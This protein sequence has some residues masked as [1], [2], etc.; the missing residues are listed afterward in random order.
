MTQSNMTKPPATESGSST[1]TGT[2]VATSERLTTDDGKISVAQ[3]VVS[4]I[5]G[6]ACRE[7]SG[8]HAMGTSSGRTFG[9][10]REAI[11]GSLGSPN[12]AQGVSVQVG[13]TQ[14]A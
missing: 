7:I 4:K 14:A 5:A 13:E 1:P 2:G 8:V 9:V 11:P 3:S 12:V 10:I 6:V